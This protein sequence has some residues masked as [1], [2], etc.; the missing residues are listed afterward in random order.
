MPGKIL[1]T[2]GGFAGFWAAVAARRVAGPKADVRL[3]SREPVLEVRPRLYEAHPETLGVP[4]LPLLDKI[5]VTFVRGEAVG[6][7]T[8]AAAV[9]LSSG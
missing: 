4:L 6:L 3:V 2:G 8:S 1:V 9:T 7:D 5:G